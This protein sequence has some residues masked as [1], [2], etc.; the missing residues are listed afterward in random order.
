LVLIQSSNEFKIHLKILLK[1][2]KNKKKKDFSILFPSFLGFSPP[3]FL[4]PLAQHAPATAAASAAQPSRPSTARPQRAG[5][6]HAQL[7]PRFPFP[8]CC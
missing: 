8:L 1:N 4:S 5:P 7:P 2:S 6:S 3:A